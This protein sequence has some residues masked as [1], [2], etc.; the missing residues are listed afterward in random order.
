MGIF[1]PFALSILLAVAVYPDDYPDRLARSFTAITPRRN[2]LYIRATWLSMALAIGPIVPILICT[3]YIGIF[4]HYYFPYYVSILERYFIGIVGITS[5]SLV[6]ILICSGFHCVVRKNY[7]RWIWTFFCRDIRSE[8]YKNST[9]IEYAMDNGGG[10]GP[11]VTIEYDSEDGG[12]ATKKLKFRN[13]YKCSREEFCDILAEYLGPP[14]RITSVPTKK[15]HQP[16]LV[17]DESSENK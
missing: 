4:D 16:R 5:L 11:V 6:L 3:S 10:G 9:I 12:R 14:E 15:G 2:T 7:V 17:E 1:F 13:L 8:E